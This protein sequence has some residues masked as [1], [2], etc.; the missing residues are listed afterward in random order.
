MANREIDL[1]AGTAVAVP[2]KDV[3]H[4][5][6]AVRSVPFI[7]MRAGTHDNVVVAPDRDRRWTRAIARRN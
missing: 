6:S 3:E 5:A 7:I 1:D 4:T 2:R